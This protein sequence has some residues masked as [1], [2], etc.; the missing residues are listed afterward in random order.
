[1]ADH[2]PGR[3]SMERQFSDA[4]AATLDRMGNSVNWWRGCPP[5][6]RCAPV[7]A[8]PHCFPSPRGRG[9]GGGGVAT[10]LAAL[11]MLPTPRFAAADANALWQIVGE[12]CVP[13]EKQYHSPK[14]CEQVDLAGGY[15]V[16]KD[17]VG[18]H[19]V[20]A[21]PDHARQRDREP[22]DPRPERAELLGSR[23]A[24]ASLRRGSRA[25]SAAP[26]RHRPGDQFGHA[27]AR[28]ISCIS[29]STACGST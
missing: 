9:L 22:R 20:P 1:M 13:D 6:R 5:A 28:R 15:A 8:P 19:A 10:L 2:A 16:L 3:M 25:P 12:R 18:Q 29:I 7:V 11:L 24:G 4:T 26:R 21:D 23:L 17:I 14:P 27:G